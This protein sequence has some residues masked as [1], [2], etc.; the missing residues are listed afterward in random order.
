MRISI[1]A[2]VVA[3][4]PLAPATAHAETNAAI[5][6]AEESVASS[7]APDSAL[8]A[9]ATEL[10]CGRDASGTLQRV[11]VQVRLPSLVEGRIVSAALS[12]KSVLQYPDLASGVIA[13]TAVDDDAWSADTLTWNR[14]P[15]VEGE[16]IA[17]VDARNLAPYARFTVDVTELA[18]GEQLGDGTL[19][20]RWAALDESGRGAIFGTNG[21]PNGGFHLELELAP[22]PGV[23]AGDV[24]GIDGEAGIAV[25][26]ASGLQKRMARLDFVDWLGALARD[27][28][29]GSLVV[30]N[31]RH[32]GSYLMRIDPV[33]G[34]DARI[35][36]SAALPFLGSIA[37][38]AGGR[39][40]VTP[41][42]DF[43]RDARVL[44]IDARSGE[45]HEVAS[46]APLA[47]PAGIAIAPGGALLVADPAARAVFRIDPTSGAVTVV[48]SGGLARAPTSLA[49]DPGGDIYVGDVEWPHSVLRVDPAS[50][51][52]S[53]VS[54]IP[55]PPNLLAPEPTGSLLVSW[56]MP[57]HTP[58]G[59][60]LARLDPQS[61]ALTELSS[62][63]FGYLPGGLT[64]HPNGT[65]FL[66][67]SG[68][69]NLPS[70]RSFDPVTRRQ[71]LVAA[72]LGANGFPYP[73][74]VD[75]DRRLVLSQWDRVFRIDPTSGARLLVA[76]P[77]ELGVLVDEPIS[78][79][80][81]GDVVVRPDGRIFVARGDEIVEIDPDQGRHRVVASGF[82]FVEALA[83]DR[84]GMQLA[85]R[86]R[87]SSLGSSILWLVDPDRGT[88]SVL[89]TGGPLQVP[90]DLVVDRNGTIYAVDASARSIYRVDRASGS[91]TLVARNAASP[92]SSY[93][94]TTI[95][96]DPQ[97]RLVT[98]SEW[99]VRTDPETGSTERL[100]SAGQLA[101]ALMS[102][103]V[104]RPRCDDAMDND[105]DARTDWPTDTDC[106]SAADDL[107][108]P[109]G[110]GLGFELA[111]LLALVA[112]RSGMRRGRLWRAPSAPPRP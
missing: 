45:L 41:S 107:E 77:D 36:D 109:H 58:T 94:P 73:I 85:G 57:P 59:F 67:V 97:G 37:I 106:F 80:G 110:C 12:G 42:P 92:F 13:L 46:G 74:A 54:E 70:V 23:E 3:L 50:G 14:Q 68:A 105:D 60:Y 7:A 10:P 48:T 103:A 35:G 28:T 52:Q 62:Q 71:A 89:S 88:K 38:D 66:S 24:V 5:Q 22:R 69:N 55:V 102:I 64:V 98:G 32:F 29:D 72:P 16:P 100:A 93:G 101:S 90:E 112:R 111:P 43:R 51:G 40:F 2:L 19:S 84:D 17:I 82:E 34:I 87:S 104:V 30:E 108:R 47:A 27:P 95:D 44:R 86:R 4:A 15:A 33:T 56:S 26:T 9:T 8:G 18:R 96:V 81:V 11:F 79:T 20:L 65:A 31:R 76:N 6:A 53:L 99:L 49:I 83:T 25:D 61:G 63:P 39:I 75:P 78:A 91:Q 1:L 21:S